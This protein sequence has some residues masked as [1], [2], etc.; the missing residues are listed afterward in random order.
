MYQE[1]LT[2]NYNCNKDTLASFCNSVSFIACSDWATSIKLLSGNG[3]HSGF[4]SGVSLEIQF[5]LIL[6]EF[7]VF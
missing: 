5:V 7:S 3:L 4:D 2:V 1:L 6:L